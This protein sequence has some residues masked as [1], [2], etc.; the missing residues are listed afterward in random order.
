MVCNLLSSVVRARAL[1]STR[2][3]TIGAGTAISSREMLSAGALP[4]GGCGVAH[5]RPGGQNN[6]FQKETD[7]PFRSEGD[8]SRCGA[9]HKY[10]THS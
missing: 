5:G 10:S 9:G 1:A 6:G 7:F 3:C 2:I 8:D 4:A